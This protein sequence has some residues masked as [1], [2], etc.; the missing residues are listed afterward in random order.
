MHL[1]VLSRVGVYSVFCSSSNGVCAVLLVF[2]ESFLLR[3]LCIPVYTIVLFYTLGQ[4]VQTILLH[5]RVLF[6]KT[7]LIVNNLQSTWPFDQKV[8]ISRLQK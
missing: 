6:D 4:A 1:L 8:E 3:L 2:F 7:C 5:D